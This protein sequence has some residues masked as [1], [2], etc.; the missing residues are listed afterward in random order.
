MIKLITSWIFRF[1]FYIIA[2]LI[3][4]VIAVYLSLR[5][6]YQWWRHP[7][8]KL[9]TKRR[10]LPPACLNDPS[11]GEHFYIQIKVSRFYLF[12]LFLF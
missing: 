5:I 7:S 10:E 9:V 3:A 1:S 8:E 4:S 2:Y 11:L 6:I 12:F